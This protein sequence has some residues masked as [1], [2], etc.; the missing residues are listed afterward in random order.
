MSKDK[1]INEAIDNALRQKEWMRGAFKEAG[2]NDD[3]IHNVFKIKLLTIDKNL[4]FTKEQLAEEA[5]KFLTNGYMK[6]CMNM[7][8]ATDLLKDEPTILSPLK[9]S[10]ISE[11]ELLTLGAINYDAFLYV[12]ENPQYFI[13]HKDVFADFV[14]FSDIDTDCTVLPILANN[15]DKTG[16]QSLVDDGLLGKESCYAMVDIFCGRSRS[17]PNFIWNVEP[18]DIKRYVDNLD[19]LAKSG[20]T[21]DH[22]STLEK[23]DAKETDDLTRNYSLIQS[24]DHYIK[25][26][27]KVRYPRSAGESNSCSTWLCG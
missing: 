22:L 15:K 21:T 16:L 26:Y 9:D 14:S 1:D 20:I 19:K 17:L 4:S 8:N 23:A 11:N 24:A 13:Q 2:V 3:L 6:P 27:L 12:T 7:I 18:K 25:K 10:G 5:S